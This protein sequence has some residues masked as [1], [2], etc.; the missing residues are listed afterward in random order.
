MPLGLL[1]E[2]HSQHML[3]HIAI[4]LPEET[5]DGHKH[6]Y[7]V[8]HSVLIL[9]KMIRSTSTTSS[10]P[11]TMQLHVWDMSAHCNSFWPTNEEAHFQM[12]QAG[13]SSRE[14]ITGKCTHEHSSKKHAH[15]S[16]GSNSKHGGSKNKQSHQSGKLQ[17]GKAT[18][19][20]DW[21]A[22]NRCL[23]CMA[24]ASQESTIGSSKHHS[25]GKKKAKKMHKKKKSSK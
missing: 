12:P 20:E 21:Q 16:S 15:Q 5:K 8:A 11:I 7:C 10:M 9:S 19:Q 13:S 23:T 17:P 18:S 22:S 1:Q 2:L 4:F 14:I 24:G 25:G 3:A 6:G